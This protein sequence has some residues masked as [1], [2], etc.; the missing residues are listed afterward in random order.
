M[1]ILNILKKS[2]DSLCEEDL[3]YFEDELRIG[4]YDDSYVLDCRQEIGKIRL[5]IASNKPK[6]TKTRSSKK[7]DSSLIMNIADL[8]PKE[9]NP[10]AASMT[11]IDVI[12]QNIKDIRMNADYKKKF[13]KFVKSE[14]VIDGEFIETNFNFFQPWELKLLLSLID[15]SEEFLENHYNALDHEDIAIYQALSEEFY[16][17]HYQDLPVKQVLNNK[18]NMWLDKNNRSKQFDVFL[19]L[20]GIKV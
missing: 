19:R 2:T 7:A 12:K 13:V 20:K 10:I 1:D 9:A 4:E 8:A 16:I 11:N 14:P 17:K 3:K 18:K 15:F 6:P 5:W